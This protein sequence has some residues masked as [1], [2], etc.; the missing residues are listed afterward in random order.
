MLLLVCVVR[1]HLIS[2]QFFVKIV[3]FIAIAEVSD[4]CSL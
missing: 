2:A 3:Y 1:A 4:V